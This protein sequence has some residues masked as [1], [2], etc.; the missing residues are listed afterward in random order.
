[1][2][3]TS[4]KTTLKKLTIF[5]VMFWIFSQ[6]LFHLLYYKV[7][8]ISIFA[9]QDMF[10]NPLLHLNQFLIGNLAGL[11]FMKKYWREQNFLVYIILILI[12][13]IMLLKFPLGLIYSDGL[14]SVLFVPL[15]FLISLSNDSLTN[16]FKKDIFVFLGEISFSIYILQRPILK[17]LEIKSKP[18]K[19]SCKIRIFKKKFSMLKDMLDLLNIT[20]WLFNTLC[21]T[22][23]QQYLYLFKKQEFIWLRQNWYFPS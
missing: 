15:I 16:F 21:N 4:K 8:E 12:G 6:I 11:Y 7:I 9:N 18:N 1:M 5:I 3:M 13:L 20:F 22:Y 19:R 17:K 2:E 10:Y 23:N 14:L